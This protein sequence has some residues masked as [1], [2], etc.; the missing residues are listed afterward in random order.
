M[1]KSRAWFIVQVLPIASVLK[2]KKIKYNQTFN[3]SSKQ[4]IHRLLKRE[5]DAKGTHRQTPSCS[6]PIRPPYVTSASGLSAVSAVGPD[7]PRTLKMDLSGLGRW[8]VGTQASNTASE[9]LDNAN[10]LIPPAS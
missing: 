8:Q 3:Y 5:K 6:R 9:E 2:R 1:P 10:H 7:K 4:V